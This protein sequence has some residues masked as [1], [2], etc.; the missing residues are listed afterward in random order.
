MEFTR[1]DGHWLSD[2]GVPVEIDFIALTTERE[3]DQFCERLAGMDDLPPWDA[4]SL[5][6][7][8][9]PVTCGRDQAATAHGLLRRKQGA[10]KPFAIQLYE[11]FA[12]GETIEQLAAKLH[13]PVERVAM[14]IR[15]AESCLRQHDRKTA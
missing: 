7:G 2:T 4:E 14:R 8:C 5:L 1:P 12:R 9:V 15:A 10:I 3:W 13:I 6:A 11:R